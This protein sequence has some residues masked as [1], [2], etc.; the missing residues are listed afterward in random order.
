MRLESLF[1]HRSYALQRELWVF[2][3]ASLPKHPQPFYQAGITL[4][5]KNEYILAEKMLRKAVKLAPTDVSIH[6]MHGSLVVLNL[7]HNR[8]DLTTKTH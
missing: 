4:K 8:R 6:R 2:R 3:R 7:V 1:N 5:E